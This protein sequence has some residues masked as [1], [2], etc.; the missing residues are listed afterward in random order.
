[1]MYYF[2][3]HLIK[4]VVDKFKWVRNILDIPNSFVNH[5]NKKKKKDK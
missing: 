5:L 3:D 2:P 4:K 1:M